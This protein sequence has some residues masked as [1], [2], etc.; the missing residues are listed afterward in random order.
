MS[1]NP[2]CPICRKPLSPSG[3]VKKSD[4]MATDDLKD[5]T[6]SSK[7]TAILSKI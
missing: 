4:F 7:V 5:L 1:I 2:N 3:Y 6:E